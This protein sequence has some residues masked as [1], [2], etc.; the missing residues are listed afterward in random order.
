MLLTPPAPPLTRGGAG[1]SVA[2]RAARAATAASALA[3]GLVVVADLAAPSALAAAAPVLAAAGLLLGLPHGA[4]DHMVPFWSTGE[5]ATARRLAQVLASYLLVA[6]LAAAALVAVPDVALAVFLVVSALH[7]GRGDVVFAAERAERS[8]P[9]LGA[10]LAVTLAHGAVVVALPYALWNEVAAP[11]LDDLAPALARPPQ[12]VLTALV[13]ATAALV[14]VAGAHLVRRRRWVEVGELALLALCFATVAPLAAF[15]VYFGLWHAGRHTARMVA[16]AGEGPD[17]SA[18]SALGRYVR[19][20]A[21]PTA[22]AAGALVAVA[23][24]D[25]RSVLATQI[26]VLLALT[27]PHLQTVARLD[28]ARR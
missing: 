16:L 20:A 18:A 17:R 22:V 21:A 26:A 8:V 19:H 23:L 1:P 2:A 6:A 14:L 27:F 28:A 10:E 12:A 25:D 15:G 5:A 24:T 13:V 7:F 9:P 4:V 3:V 11:V